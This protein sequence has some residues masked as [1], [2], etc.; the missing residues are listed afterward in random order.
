M[1]RISVLMPAYNSMT[2]IAAAIASILNQTYSNFELIIID[3]AS[4]D[5]TKRVIDQ[6]SDSRIK[7]HSNTTNLG[8]TNSLNVALS[9][10]C[11]EYIARMD[12]DDIALP[13]RL[14]LQV[15]HLAADPDLGIVGGQILT[16][17]AQG[18]L[19]GRIR[20]PISHDAILACATVVPPFVHPSVMIR[21]KVFESNNLKY[22]DEAPYAEDYVLWINILR[23]WKGLNLKQ[24]VLRY[25]VHA[26]S[27]S[28]TQRPIQV[29]SHRMA[30]EKALRTLFFVDPPHDLCCNIA[31]SVCTHAPLKLSD[32]RQWS[33][34]M[35]V[36]AKTA[37]I[38][39]PGAA[40]IHSS[41]FSAEAQYQL[42]R[43]GSRL[44]YMDM[45]FLASSL[46]PRL[47]ISNISYIAA[48]LLKT[49]KAKIDYRQTNSPV[50]WSLL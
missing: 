40:L 32:L 44:S 46:A 30:I 43:L 15:Q 34:M 11:G 26:G 38:A 42:L 17:D 20:T 6:F 12:A 50:G 24:D 28:H 3:D 21:T 37:A 33:D 18:S 49:L 9:L 10:A 25:R 39:R 47:S 7:V 36:C 29:H 22:T 31:S 27:S 48:I 13:T 14:E 45:P 4:T 16:M 41:D 2:T 1:P 8:I 23:Q 35:L 5:Q 19:T